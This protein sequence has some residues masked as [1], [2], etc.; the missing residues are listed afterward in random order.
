MSTCFSNHEE[1]ELTNSIVKD[2]LLCSK[3]DAERM[4]CTLPGLMVMLD[5]IV[6][7]SEAGPSGK[8]SSANMNQLQLGSADVLTCDQT[9]ECEMSRMF[10]IC[11]SLLWSFIIVVTRSWFGDANILEMEPWSTSHCNLRQLTFVA[12]KLIFCSRSATPPCRFEVFDTTLTDCQLLNA[13]ERDHKSQV[14]NW[15][16]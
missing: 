11:S 10:V 1:V 15:Q 7:V 12:L 4:S 3:H 9:S 6:G 8:L 14:M 13:H 2:I 16:T 5:D